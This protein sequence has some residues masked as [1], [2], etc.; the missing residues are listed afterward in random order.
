MFSA[1]EN[2]RSYG[3]LGWSRMNTL[4]EIKTNIVK[5]L[6]TKDST[7]MCPLSHAAA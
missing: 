1:A 5:I 2:I 6:N 4:I 3:T 7:V